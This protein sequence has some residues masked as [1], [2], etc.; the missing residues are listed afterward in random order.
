[1][2]FPSSEQKVINI[3]A[4]INDKV[5]WETRIRITMNKANS[6]VLCLQEELNF[7][8]LEV[9]LTIYNAIVCFIGEYAYEFLD[10]KNINVELKL[11]L[12]Q[13]FCASIYISKK[14]AACLDK[15]ALP[16][17]RVTLAQVAKT[18]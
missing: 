3:F 18:N 2:T 5:A 10:P 12:L 15:P 7:S 16:Y 13:R 17:D 1:M 11:E 6:E 14:P 9:N 8:T 4:I